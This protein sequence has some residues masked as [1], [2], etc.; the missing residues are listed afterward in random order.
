MRMS[1]DSFDPDEVLSEFGDEATAAELAAIVRTALERAADAGDL[2]RVREVAHAVKGAAGTVSADAVCQLASRIETGL[3]R[4]DDAVAQFAPALAAECRRL[5]RD[6]E[7]WL[8]AL[9]GQ[10]PV[11][12]QPGNSIR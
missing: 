6:L 8:A 10:L 12:V 1:V 9:R 3:R 7:T 5:A 4:G 11:S 2:T